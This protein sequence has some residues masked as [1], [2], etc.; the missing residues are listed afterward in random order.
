MLTLLVFSTKGLKDNCLH[1]PVT[2]NVPSLMCLP[3]LPAICEISFKFS[4]LVFFPS[5][6]F[7]L[8]KLILL[9]SI[10]IQEVV[11]M[12]SYNA[13][14]YL[15]LNDIGKIEQG[16]KSNFLVLDKNLKLQDVY[17]NGKKIN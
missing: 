14:K 2:P 9:I 7:K 15:G 16:Y 17:L 6:F 4:L 5:N 3:A 10:F 13:S 12:T 1:S 11:S 8:L